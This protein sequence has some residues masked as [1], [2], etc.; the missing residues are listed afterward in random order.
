MRTDFNLNMKGEVWSQ[1]EKLISK[2]VIAY[3]IIN[4]L[5]LLTLIW[6]NNI[7]SIIILS[8]WFFTVVS[9]TYYVFDKHDFK[10]YITFKELIFSTPSIFIA[11]V[12]VYIVSIYLKR[13]YPNSNDELEILKFQ[14]LK[15]IKQVDLK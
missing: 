13:N 11:Y 10:E 12:I 15:K 1:F 8:I 14:R 7:L 9:S 6:F 5:P 2:I 3:I 4:L